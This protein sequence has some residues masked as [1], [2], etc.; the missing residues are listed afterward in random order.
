[1]IKKNQ[2][3]SLIEVLIFT[4]IL[5]LFFVMAAAVTVNSLRDMKYNEHKI[6]ATFLTENTRSVI[7]GIKEGNWS[8]LASK[9]FSDNQ[10]SPTSY[11]FNSNSFPYPVVPNQC[12]ATE[13]SV[14]G[15]YKREIFLYE[16]DV[17][18]PTKINL[19]IEVSWRELG[20]P[21]QV[22]SSTVYTIWE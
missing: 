21:R 20:L 17:N 13:Y 10:L 6:I 5:S 11:C 18:Q 19:R 16:D 7:T 4:A 2:S 22:S 14:R 3:F 15:M 9:V 12:G 8:N 1:M